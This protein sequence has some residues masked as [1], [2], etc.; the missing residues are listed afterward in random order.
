MVCGAELRI[1]VRR[2]RL[3]GESDPGGRGAGQGLAAAEAEEAGRRLQ[4]PPP[5]LHE[6]RV[7]GRREVEEKRKRV[8]KVYSRTS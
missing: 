5:G 3:G 6:L 4:A 7:L 2:L 1:T 8:R